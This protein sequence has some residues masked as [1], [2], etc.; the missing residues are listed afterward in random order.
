M[1][2]TL[3]IG[4]DDFTRL[5]VSK[6]DFYWKP[7]AADQGTRVVCVEATDTYGYVTST[8]YSLCILQII[9]PRLLVCCFIVL[10]GVLG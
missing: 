9:L 10:Y 1:R 2:Q 4:N 7:T 3:V 8:I 6:T 5:G